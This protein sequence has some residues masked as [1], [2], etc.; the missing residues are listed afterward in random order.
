MRDPNRINLFCN[1]LAVY[2]REYFP[3]IRFG[4]IDR[5]TE[6]KVD[7]DHTLHIIE[8]IPLDNY[9]SIPNACKNCSNHPS[10]GGSGIC[11]CTLGGPTI[12]C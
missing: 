2:W 5:A 1:D 6:N 3:D 8:N 12:I 9:V 7:K 11:N 10:N 4:T